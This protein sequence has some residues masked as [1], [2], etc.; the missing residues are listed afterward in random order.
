MIALNPTSLLLPITKTSAMTDH[1]A[2]HEAETFP[3]APR[4]TASD[5]PTPYVGP[6]RSDYE[7]A[8]GKT[9]GDGS[10]EWWGKVSDITC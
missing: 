9:V 5:R 2:L 6:A 7:S 3:V 8:H 10:D 1:A 4:L